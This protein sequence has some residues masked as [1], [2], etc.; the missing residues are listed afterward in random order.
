[1]LRHTISPYT[2]LFRSHGDGTQTRCF[3]HVEDTIRALSALMDA[4][5]LDGDLFNVGS[6]E[7]VSIDELARRVLAATGSSSEIVHIPYDERSEEHTSELQSRGH[8]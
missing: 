7:R 3:C 8:L 4:P 5:G 6:T 2:T 1:L